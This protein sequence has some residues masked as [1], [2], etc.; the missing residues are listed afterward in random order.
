MVMVLDMDGDRVS[1]SRLYYRRA[2]IDGVQH[3]RDRILQEVQVLE[4][5]PGIIGPYQDALHSA[6]TDGMLATFDENGIFNGHGEHTDLHQGL[7]MGIYNGREAMR[8][9]LDQMFSLIGAAMG[10]PRA[11]VNLQKMNGFT[12][13]RTYVLE[14]TMID[15]NHPENRVHAGVAVYEIGDSGLIKEARI[16]DEAW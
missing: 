10:K 13:G 5:Y 7:G 2:R 16:F 11:S 8:P 6:D 1:R 3:V 4:S 15:P 14:F 12:D 9:A